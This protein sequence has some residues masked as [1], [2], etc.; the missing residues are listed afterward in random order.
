MDDLQK[1]H[2]AA[3]AFLRPM[4]ILYNAITLV[5]PPESLK[6]PSIENIF[7]PLCRYLGLPTTILE[8]IAGQE[9]EHLFQMYELLYS[10]PDIQNKKLRW[11]QH[12]IHI[13]LPQFPLKLN[14]LIELPNDF[15]QLINMAVNFHCPQMQEMTT[16]IP[17]LCLLCGEMLCKLF[18]S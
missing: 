18:I 15:S 2:A 14:M 4:A 12:T 6:D 3:L 7:V 5:P 16:T 1:L 8:L 13:E 9:V 17:T 11:S 10:N